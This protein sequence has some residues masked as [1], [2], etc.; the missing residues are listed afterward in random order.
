[1]AAL[2]A[3]GALGGSETLHEEGHERVSELRA[4]RGCA[5]ASTPPT[6]CWNDA[7]SAFRCACCTNTYAWLGSGLGSGGA[8]E[9]SAVSATAASAAS[10]SRAAVD[11][12]AIVAARPSGTEKRGGRVVLYQAPAGGAPAV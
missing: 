10:A 9:A 12:G 7:I 6:I 1:M 3:L 8:T 2:L 4:A 11:M 5:A